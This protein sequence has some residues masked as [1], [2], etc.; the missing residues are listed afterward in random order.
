MKSRVQAQNVE[1]Q[2]SSSADQ[3]QRTRAV[4][5]CE[6]VYK[7]SDQVHVSCLSGFK[8]LERLDLGFNSLTSLEGLKLCLNLKW[9]S[10]VQNKLHSLKGIE[11]LTKLTVLNAG[12]NKLKSM[13]EVMSLGSLRALILNDNEISSVCKLDLMKELNTLVLSRNPIRL[14]GESLIELKSITK[15]S[16]SKCQLQTID[17]SLNSCIELKEL[18]LAHNEITIIPSHIS[19]L[20]KLQNLDLGNNLI[21]KWSNVKELA[22]MI[23]LKNL[24]LQGNPIAGKGNLVRKVKNL[25]PNLHIFNAKPIEK[26]L[27]KEVDDST[28]KTHKITPIQ[29]EKKTSHALRNKN[30]SK[31]PAVDETLNTH[32]EDAENPASKNKKRKQLDE[33][34]DNLRKTTKM[35]KLNVMDDPET[36]LVD[37]FASDAPEIPTK[38]GDHKSDRVKVDSAMKHRKARKSTKR[39]NLKALDNSRYP[40]TDHFPPATPEI[41]AEDGFK[42]LSRDQIFRDY[43]RESDVI[44]MTIYKR[45]KKHV[46]KVDPAALSELD[47]GSGGASSWV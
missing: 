21:T 28:D 24:N 29:D 35:D 27:G 12:K 33:N 22:P 23:G 39:D 6:A 10:V 18:R 45:N 3:V 36:P 34:D 47:V 8:N 32:L 4:I 15:L 2:N 25:L 1:V 5:G 13:D 41:P 40:I 14:L 42:R 44:S 46:N 11:G 38:T 43:D 17:S 9:L 19:R 37:L 26:I 20:T 30:S 7:S 16:V 31:A